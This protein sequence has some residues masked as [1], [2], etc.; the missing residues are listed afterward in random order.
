MVGGILLNQS[1]MGT[2][3][4][5]WADTGQHTGQ[6]FWCFLRI[7]VE[8]SNSNYRLRF[9]GW[10]LFPLDSLFPIWYIRKHS[11]GPFLIVAY[12]HHPHMLGVQQF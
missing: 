8:L 4:K 1:S 9:L 11:T 3:G 10:E 12:L 7:G 6:G 2:Y 5:G